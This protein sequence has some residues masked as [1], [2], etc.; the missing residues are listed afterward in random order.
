MKRTRTLHLIHQL[1][2]AGARSP[3]RELRGSIGG[4]HRMSSE[5]PANFRPGVLLTT[6]SSKEE[7][8]KIAK[9][10][11]ADRLAACCQLKQIFSVYSW[12]EEICQDEEYQLLAKINLESFKEV[13]EKISQLHTYDTPEI[14]SIPIEEGSP[15][16][17][18]WMRQMTC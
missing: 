3:A 9:S 13:S 18:A 11:V 15:D 12:K 14:I 5:A 16:Y 6:T 8:V 7:A 2:F 4:A 1:I 17:M 10:L